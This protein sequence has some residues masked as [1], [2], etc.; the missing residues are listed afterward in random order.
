MVML[1]AVL[2]VIFS[3]NELKKK[4]VFLKKKEIEK[5]YALTFFKY[6]YHHRIC[7]HQFLEKIFPQADP[8]RDS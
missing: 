7:F 5:N 6:T 8:R 4:T 3:A 2:T 1:K